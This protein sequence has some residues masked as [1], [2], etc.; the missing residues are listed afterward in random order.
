M[1]QR[2][3]VT[4]V[5]SLIYEML[6]L[7]TSFSQSF[8]KFKYFWRILHINLTQLLRI[9]QYLAKF[10]IDQ[11]T[12]YFWQESPDKLKLQAFCHRVLKYLHEQGNQSFFHEH[13]CVLAFLCAETVNG[14]ERNSFNSR[15]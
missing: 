13:V 5:L 8:L 3:L 2:S 11:N 10:N 14:C 9:D 15:L 6:L 7:E 1:S 4:T 12:H